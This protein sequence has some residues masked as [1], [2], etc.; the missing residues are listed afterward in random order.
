MV[1]AET[2]RRGDAERRKVTLPPRDQERVPE[3]WIVDPDSRIAERWRPDDVRPEVI[4]DILEWC[5]KPDI[6]PLRIELGAVVA[7]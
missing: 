2:R 4:A 6:E 5:P 1:H 7:G 3:Y